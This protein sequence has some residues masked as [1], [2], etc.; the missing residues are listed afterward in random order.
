MGNEPDM[1][2]ITRSAQALA[3]LLLVTLTSIGASAQ[4]SDPATVTT[5]ALEMT[6]LRPHAVAVTT[7][8][9]EM[10]GLRSDPVAVETGTLEMTGVRPDPVSVT[11]RALEMSGLRPDPVI[12][13]TGALEMTGLRP[14]PV[15]VATGALEMTGLRPDPVTVTTNA[16]EMTGLRGRE[17]QVEP[18]ASGLATPPADPVTV[19]TGAL[20]MTGLRPDPVAVATGALEMTGLRPNPVTVATAALEMTGLRPNPV[21]VATGAL[22]MTGLRQDPVTVAT[23]TLEMTGLRPAPLTVATGG[24]E[25]TGLRPDP[26]TVDTGALEMTGLRDGTDENPIADLAG[27]TDT[28]TPDPSAPPVGVPNLKIT[29]SSADEETDAC[30]AG[31]LCNYEVVVASV[32]SAPFDGMA[33]LRIDTDSEEFQLGEVDLQGSR[34]SCVQFQRGGSITCLTPSL[35]LEVGEASL[36]TVSLRA[37]DDACATLAPPDMTEQPILF[38]QFILALNGFDPGPIDGRMGGRTAAALEAF[39]SREGLDITGTP[40]AQTLEAFVGLFETDTDR[41]DD[42]ACLNAPA[43]VSCDNGERVV[44]GQCVPHCPE[45]NAYWDGDRCLTCETGTT[46]NAGTLRCDDDRVADASGQ[47][48]DDQTPVAPTRDVLANL[49]IRMPGTDGMTCEAG[50]WCTFEAVVVSVSDTPFEGMISAEAA[51]DIDDYRLGEVGPDGNVWSC[52]QDGRGNPATCLSVPQRLE[53]GASSQISV[54]FRIP[55]S[56]RRD[57]QI[58]T[59]FALAPPDMD[60]E[61]VLF[62]QIVLT[63]IGIDPGPI[64]GAMGGRTAAGLETFQGREGLDVTGEPDARTLAA[65]KELFGADANPG[66]DRACRI[67]TVTKTLRCG[68][69]EK[70]E[71]DVCVARCPTRNEHWNG[72]RCVSCGRGTSWNADRRRC[73]ENLPDCDAATTTLSDGECRCTYLNMERVNTTTCRCPSGTELVAG[74]GCV[75]PQPQ[76]PFGQLYNAAKGAC[77]FLCIPPGYSTSRGCACPDG[78]RY[79]IFRGCTVD[80]DDGSSTPGR[81]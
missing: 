34:W 29:F 76:C 2:G 23:A 5:D 28:D 56:A 53:I 38:S 19:T 77:E 21:S 17:P 36:F 50:D 78:G 11:T 71:G 75:T 12:V 67:V 74:Q 37:P 8:A 30:E 59:C 31:D 20:E 48:G 65:L 3:V 4:S 62:S 73:V 22:E 26:I 60:D 35:H 46:W 33:G 41:R 18:G 40:D 1:P 69:S 47:A 25:M 58:E 52:V 42:R 43:V 72:E 32:G 79:R 9:L 51:M 39:Q 10:T 57:D 45:T 54:S 64:D 14:D 27:A 68:F 81:N 24:L 7:G 13:E 16:L 55:E 61:P 15:A 70:V 6:G 63:L 49:S 44:D 80:D 66:D